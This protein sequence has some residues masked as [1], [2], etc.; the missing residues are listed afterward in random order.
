MLNLLALLVVWELADIAD[1]QR[2]TL[3]AQEDAK[4]VPTLSDAKKAAID[5][6]YAEHPHLRTRNSDYGDPNRATGAEENAQ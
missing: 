3:Q 6:F 5:K 4:P 2:A 1:V